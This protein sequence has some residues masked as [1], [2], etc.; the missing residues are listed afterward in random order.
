MDYGKTLDI[1]E[2]DKIFLGTVFCFKIS[3][4]LE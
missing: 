4:S 2:D 3:I 1:V